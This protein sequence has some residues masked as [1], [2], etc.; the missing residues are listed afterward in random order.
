MRILGTLGTAV[1]FLLFKM[2]NI[3]LGLVLKS[4]ALSIVV[5][6]IE[7]I[8][9]MITISIEKT[10]MPCLYKDRNTFFLKIKIKVITHVFLVYQHLTY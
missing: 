4:D 5:R 2:N 6:T 7:M 9:F 10:R 1:S 3:F 8:D